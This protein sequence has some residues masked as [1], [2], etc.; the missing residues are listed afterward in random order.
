[1]EIKFVKGLAILDNFYNPDELP[2]VIKETKEIYKFRQNPDR[3]GSARDE[4]SKIKKTGS[5]IFLYPIHLSA[6]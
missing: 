3:T 6:C 4:Q 1:M 2:D 5:G